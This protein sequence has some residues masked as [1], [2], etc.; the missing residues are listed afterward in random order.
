MRQI[1]NFVFGLL[2]VTTL[3]A[4]SVDAQQSTPPPAEAPVLR[5][6][7]QDALDRARRNSVTYQAAA[8]EARIAHEDKKQSVAALLPS[9]NYDNSAIYTEGTGA[10]SN[11][12]KFVANNAVHEYFSQGNIHQALD[13]AGFAGARRA[14]ALAAAAH[15]RAEVAARGLVVTVVQNYFAVT[16]ARAKLEAAQSAADEGARFLKL[17][18]DLEHG[19]EVAHSDVIKAELQANDRS[20][21]LQEE[22]LALLNARL[23]LSVLI[24]SDFTDN[25]DLAEDLHA[26][27]PLPT[28]VDFQ[29]KTGARNPE[30]SAAI[31]S[32][33]AAGDG[34]FA[35]RAA[36]LLR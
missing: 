16:A 30:V 27:V 22:N 21:Q 25:F 17:T 8:T 10:G 23:D 15:A 26:S 34:V 4:K 28:L 14:S 18:Q 2:L 3:A 33:R 6:T 36:Y 11:S 5:L 20:R 9:F 31:E 7:L 19:G 12:V 24:F 13:V 29:A 35:A 1:Y 32:A